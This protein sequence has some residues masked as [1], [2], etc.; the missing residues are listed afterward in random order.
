MKRNVKVATHRNPD[1]NQD[2]DCEEIESG[3][4]QESDNEPC[5]DGEEDDP[6]DPIEL[7]L[8]EVIEEI[9]PCL[10]YKDVKL[11]LLPNPDGIRE[12]HAME[13]DLR[14]TKGWQRKWKR[15]II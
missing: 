5:S 15:Y 14:F 6:G 9:I 8:E 7:T 11:I 4:E 10:R 13:I 12:V 1:W 2:D 3:D